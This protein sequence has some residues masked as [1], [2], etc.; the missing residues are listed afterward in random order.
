VVPAGRTVV[1][2]NADFDTHHIAVDAGGPDAGDI[3][4][5]RFSAPVVVTGAG[6]YHCVIHPS[7]TGALQRAE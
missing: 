2:H 1:W 4:P 7:M 3:R 6:R 5:G